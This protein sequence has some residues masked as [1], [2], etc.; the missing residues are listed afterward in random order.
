M[1]ARSTQVSGKILFILFLSLL[2]LPSL[3]YS[4]C[5]SSITLKSQADVNSFLCSSVSGNLIIDGADIIDLSPLIN[6]GKL[7]SVSGSVIVRNCVKLSSLKGL[8]LI[9]SIGGNFELS[10]LANLSSW[11]SSNFKLEKV[12]Q[13]I[14]IN[15]TPELGDVSALSNLTTVGFGILMGAGSVVNN[16][17]GFNALSFCPIVQLFQTNS[18]IVD[19][20]ASLSNTSYLNILSNPILEKVVGFENLSSIKT[21]TV[22]GS[23][24]QFLQVSDNKNLGSLDAFP[25]LES[26]PEFYLRDNTTFSNCCF[27]LDIIS[28]KPDV[29]SIDNNG[30]GC[31]SIGEIDAPP[32]L[33]S[34]PANI[35]VGTDAG[36]CS[37]VFN[38]TDPTASDNCDLN[39]YKLQFLDLSNNILL[40]LNASNGST[41]A[42]EANT[43]EINAKYIVTDDTG[44]SA[45][46][47]TNI[48]ITDNEAPK[49]SAE[50]QD[51]SISTVAN[52]CSAS[53]G[54]NFPQATD[55][56]SIVRAEI[57]IKPSGGSAV[58][59]NLNATI[60]NSY[61]T[62]LEPGTYT[63]EMTVYDNEELKDITSATI[64]VNDNIK[65]I[66]S[67]ISADVTINCNDNF[68][69]IPSPIANDNCSGSLTGAITASSSV[70][71]GDCSLGGI[72][73][74][75]E[76]SWQV[77]DDAGNTASASWIV[78]II[79]DFSFDLGQDAVLC[80]GGSSYTIDPGN[81]GDAYEWSTGSNAQSIDVNASGN[82]SVTITTSNGCC[83]S[84]DINVAIGTLPSASASGGVLGCTDASIQLFGSSTSSG[85]SYDWSGP[86]NF[87]S[88][89]QNPIV[90]SAG[91]YELFVTS[92]DG[93]SSTDVA[94]VSSD[95]DVPDISTSGGEL[96]CLAT[97][98][99]LSGSS[100]TPNVTFAWTGPNNFSSSDENPQ[101]STPG[102][103]TLEI[104]SPNGCSSSLDATVVDNAQSP[105]ANISVNKID[106]ANP[107][108]TIVFNSE[109]IIS[110]LS[111]TGPNNFSSE[112]AEPTVSEPGEYTL[113]VTGINGCSSTLNVTVGSNFDIPDASATGGVLSCE[114]NDII[115]N[116]SSS[117]EGVSYLW[118][119]PDEFSSSLQNPPVTQPGTYTVVVTAVNG[120]TNSAEAVVIADG[121]IPDVSAIGEAITC[122]KTEVTLM[123]SSSSPNT[124]G[125]WAGPNGFSSSES[126]P[127]VSFPGV[128]TYT[129]VAENGCEA[130]KDVEVIIDRK[131][132]DL[133]LSEGLIDCEEGSRKFKLETDATNPVFIWKG[134]GG[135]ASNLQEPTYTKAGVYNIEIVGEN[136]CTTA[137]AIEVKFDIPF[138]IDLNTTGSDA[139]ISIT[140][141]TPPFTISWDNGKEGESTSGLTS[142]NHTVVVSDGLGC[143]K[144]LVFNV[145]VSSTKELE[146][147]LN[148][149]LFPNPAN[150]Q[151]TMEWDNSERQINSISIY[152]LSGQIISSYKQLS[153]LSRKTI[154][155]S[156]FKSGIYL[157]TLISEDDVLYRKLIKN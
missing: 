26:V 19:G 39:T 52:S 106:C 29:L 154:D 146:R 127:V 31:K 66:L 149:N 3:T 67:G 138:E 87:S 62:D 143:I 122:L 140:G 9:G 17:N 27:I 23:K 74:I 93:C 102:V 44:K 34:C 49:F 147:T 32:S 129:V 69:S 82:Y 142:G 68:P 72:S 107:E 100:N 132:P 40:E 130:F 11:G 33:G 56:C 15:N 86:G 97:T 78:T 50:V 128:Y 14:I 104:T 22:D 135:F 85:V 152:N 109:A 126:N 59:T 8:E 155:I 18:S 25:N 37:A 28:L 119:G 51:E 110:S 98:V 118:S 10:N 157:L 131:D 42:Y 65:P 136:G 47:S 141:G 60:G 41:N 103:Y 137:G 64:T 45:S 121:D 139:S 90:T 99:Q 73:E 133:I 134:P 84:D 120:C 112:I 96:T 116:S 13:Y 81:I 55:N 92:T 113:V 2:I 53:Y 108:V 95:T 48:I 150:S 153:P 63:I 101:V 24:Y 4:Q 21:A 77:A 105:Q 111:W 148:I 115:I 20:F 54:F 123:G 91:E 57:V 16:F 94:I 5:G 117:V 88:S 12:D 79:S 156:S 75:H 58:Y 35:N 7:S 80:D 76:Y 125:S 145:T 38:L 36:S 114:I 43:G 151:V 30:S 144:S 71:I 83:Y 1:K 89:D 70:S 46:C 124:T 61:E 6:N